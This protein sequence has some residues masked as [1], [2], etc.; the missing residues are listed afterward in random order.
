MPAALFFCAVPLLLTLLFSNFNQNKIMFEKFEKFAIS[1]EESAT[2]TGGAGFCPAH[3]QE[4]GAC[5]D[6]W[7]DDEQG[8]RACC[9]TCG[10]SCSGYD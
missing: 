1:A 5:E 9:N 7:G 4:E 6:Y 2:L 8:G 3:L 10:T